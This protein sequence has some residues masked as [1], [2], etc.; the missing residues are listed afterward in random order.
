DSSTEVMGRY[1][2][3]TEIFEMLVSVVI[4][5]GSEIQ[6][7]DAIAELINE[8]KDVNALDFKGE[9]YDVGHMRGFVKTSI[10]YALRSENIRDEIIE[11]MESTLDNLKKKE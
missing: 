1:L 7:N 4:G 3:T 10:E 8:V 11:Y 9:R 5:A 6:L 2:L